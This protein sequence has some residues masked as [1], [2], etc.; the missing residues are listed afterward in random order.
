MSLLLATVL[1]A[2]AAGNVQ[3][4][5]PP[6]LDA[7]LARE[8]AGSYRLD[9]HHIID[10]GPMDE[11]GGDLAFLDQKTLRGGHLVRLPDNT[12]VAGPSFG[13]DTPHVIRAVFHRDRGGR[14]TGLRWT[15]EGLKDQWAKKIAPRVDEE[16]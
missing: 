6:K 14:V 5:P 10:L 15:G 8:Y 12:F 7:R 4:A 3:A 11:M 2:A 13:I 16:V 1:F 9:A